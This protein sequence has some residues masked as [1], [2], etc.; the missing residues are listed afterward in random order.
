[1]ALD[2]KFKKKFNKAR[3]EFKR[4]VKRQERKDA[5]LRIIGMVIS[6]SA[7]FWDT[8]AQGLQMQYSAG[9]SVPQWGAVGFGVILF[10]IGLI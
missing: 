6:L 10:L 3:E 8:I 1:M 2:N 9:F 7:F 4:S 5:F